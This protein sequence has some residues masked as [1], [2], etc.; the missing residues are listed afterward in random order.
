MVDGEGESLLVRIDEQH[1]KAVDHLRC[2]D[3]VLEHHFNI[4]DICISNCKSRVEKVLGEPLIQ[5]KEGKEVLR[6]D[7]RPQDED[8]DA[9]D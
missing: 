8:T 7:L 3:L 9:V 4:S 2:V 5:S 1:E 6:F